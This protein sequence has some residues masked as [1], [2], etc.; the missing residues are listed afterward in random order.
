MRYRYI[1]FDL[2]GTL[3]DSGEGIMNSARY[4]FEQSGLPVPDR[5][6]LRKMVGPPLSVGFPL[7]GMPEERVDEAVRLYRFRYNEGGGKFENRVYDG[8]VGL[9]AQLKDAG[10]RL[11]VAT[12]KPEQLAREILF[13]FG[14]TPYFE[15]VAGASWDQ[16]RQNKDDVIRYL[17]SVV[18]APEGAVMVGDTH[19]DV[20]GAH[21]R[22]LP[23]IGV[24]WGYGLREEIEAAGADAVVDSSA[25]LLAYLFPEGTA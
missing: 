8:I 1:F 3:T 10:C 14:L 2:D 6:E 21:K 12:S 4:A 15:Y 5:S 13:G 7:A 9:L 19:Y 20:I 17:L 24:T 18:D 22:G 25:M 23:C 11:F 16:S